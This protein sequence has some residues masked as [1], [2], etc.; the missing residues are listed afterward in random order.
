MKKVIV[1]GA[2]ISGLSAAYWLVRKGFDV[3][4]FERENRVGGVIQTLREDGYLFEKGPNS[5]LDN[6]VET[7]NSAANSTWKTNY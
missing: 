2:G 6:G 1:I 7:W 4:I 5:F 3:E